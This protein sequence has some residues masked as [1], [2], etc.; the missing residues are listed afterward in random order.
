[1]VGAAVALAAPAQAAATLT[2]N[3]DGSFTASGLSAGEVVW[4]C[5]PSIAASSCDASNDTYMSVPGGTFTVGS[6]VIPGAGGDSVTLP[7]GTFSISIGPGSGAR[8]ATLSNFAVG[9]PS[10]DSS[11][12]SSDGS[13]TAAAEG[14]SAPADV[15]QQVGMPAS[16]CASIDMPLLNW[17]GVASG[18]WGASWAEWA[19]RGQGGAVCTRTLSYSTSSGTWVIR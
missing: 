16:G 5:S 14:S 6:T 3:G 15:I 19:N 2:D 1:M 18:G 4:F 7:A 11:G 13:G 8:S 10:N 9:T 17:A 12:D